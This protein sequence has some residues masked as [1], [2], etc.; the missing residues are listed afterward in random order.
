VSAASGLKAGLEKNQR[1]ERLCSQK[2]AKFAEKHENAFSGTV[3]D[4]MKRNNLDLAS[5]GRGAPPP[6]YCDAFINAR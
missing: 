4:S 3:I 6:Q 2:S 5:C 1:Q